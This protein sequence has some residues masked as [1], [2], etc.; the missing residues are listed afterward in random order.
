MVGGVVVEDVPEAVRAGLDPPDAHV[1]RD[2]EI[3]CGVDGAVGVVLE[4]GGEP[5]FFA[6]GVE[7][8]GVDGAVGDG[9]EGFGRGAGVFLLH[10][11]AVG[12]L[13]GEV[14]GALSGAD[15]GVLFLFQLGE[16]AAAFVGFGGG[17]VG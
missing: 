2:A 8:E 10:A 3:P 6:Q 1:V 11:T 12:F 9:V 15:G 14:P 7:L 13:V 4:A 17:G 16:V 5:A